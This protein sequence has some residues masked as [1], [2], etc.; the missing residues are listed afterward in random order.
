MIFRSS[1]PDVAIPEAR[2]THVILEAA[3]KRPEKAAFIDGPTGRVLTFGDWAR[4]VK[5]GAFGLAARGF[6]KGDVFAIY[7][8]N[9]P[10]YAVAFHAVALAGGIVTT[11][12]PRT[13]SRSCRASS[14]TVGR[15]SS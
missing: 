12:N 13:P 11:I 14:W 1:L 15:A 2:I 3:A 4:A 6:K 7:S 5:R 8:P 10:E 9:C